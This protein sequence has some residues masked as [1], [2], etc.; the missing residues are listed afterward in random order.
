MRLGIRL[1]LE[2]NDR[3]VFIERWRQGVWHFLDGR[4]RRI[5]CLSPSFSSMFSL[6]PVFPVPKSRQRLFLGPR[7][8]SGDDNVSVNCV[9]VF[10]ASRI[11]RLT[12]PV[13]LL[14]LHLVHLFGSDISTFLY[15]NI[16]HVHLIRDPKT[17][18]ACRKYI[19]IC[20]ASFGCSILRPLTFLDAIRPSTTACRR[21]KTRNLFNS[22]FQ[23]CYSPKTN[24]SAATEKP[25]PKENYANRY[26][27]SAHFAQR[28]L[29]HH[30]P[31]HLPHKSTAVFAILCQQ[32][33]QWWKQ[34]HQHKL[35]F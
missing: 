6:Y 20:L 9:V 29:F 31:S 16:L 3:V 11:L 1:P 8:R 27:T 21:K 14:L 5:T 12:A 15:A 4:H 10:G 2:A 19:S 25:P 26:Y 32:Q 17:Q 30:Q 35:C 7:Q 22:L 13:L 18:T 34:Q 33:Q 24:H 23:H 28:Q